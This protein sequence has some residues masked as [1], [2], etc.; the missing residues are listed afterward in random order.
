M[1]IVKCGFKPNCVCSLNTG[2]HQVEPFPVLET[3]QQSIAR[4][5]EILSALEGCEITQ[6]SPTYIAATYR[7]AKLRFIDDLEFEL[8]SDNDEEVIHV[9]SA[10]R[11]GFSDLGAN[12]RRIAL[13][14]QQY[15][16][17]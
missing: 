14:R 16:D 2:L 1:K 17:R 12:R 9:K 5:R 4:L 8:G 6:E 3:P 13:L 15:H 10:S 7:T 11:V